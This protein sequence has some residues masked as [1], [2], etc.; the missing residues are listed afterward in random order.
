MRLEKSSALFF[1]LHAQAVGYMVSGMET[2]TSTT[3]EAG[4][5]L[6]ARSACDYDCIFTATVIERKGSF[7]TLL[8]HGSTTRKKIG[9][10]CDGEYVYAHGKF[11][12]APIFR[13]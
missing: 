8:V 6:K 11:S 12:M 9:R 13:P 10:D 1:W 2:N 4:Q 3:I 5:T 7:A